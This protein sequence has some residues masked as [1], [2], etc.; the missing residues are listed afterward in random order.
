MKI[1]ICTENHGV[2]KKKKKKK[3]KKEENVTIRTLSELRLWLFRT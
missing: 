1:K 3:K 2:K